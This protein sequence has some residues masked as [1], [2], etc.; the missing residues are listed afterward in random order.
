MATDGDGNIYFGA[1]YGY[2]SGI[3]K[4][5]IGTDDGYPGSCSEGI[6]FGQI[7]PGHNYYTYGIAADSNYIYRSSYGYDTLEVHAASDGAWVKTIGAM[8][9]DSWLRAP[10]ST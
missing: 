7:Y 8:A 6:P 9:Y 5:E 3:A 1:Y 10:P 4:C 2:Y